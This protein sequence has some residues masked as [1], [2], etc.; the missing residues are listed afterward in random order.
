MRSRD[1]KAS[2]TSAVYKGGEE[3]RRQL[4]VNR[5]TLEY[6]CLSAILHLS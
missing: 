5:L 6:S 4:S 1:A 3:E 2:G